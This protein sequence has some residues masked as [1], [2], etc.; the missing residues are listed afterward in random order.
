MTPFDSLLACAPA[1]QFR[2]ATSS[3][4]PAV[5]SRERFVAQIPRGPSADSGHLGS[6]LLSRTWQTRWIL[7]ADAIGLALVLIISFKWN[8]LAPELLLLAVLTL[9]IVVIV[10]FCMSATAAA[11]AAANPALP[12]SSTIQGPITVRLAPPR[13]ILIGNTDAGESNIIEHAV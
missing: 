5:A 3:G 10:H 9:L 12:V 1:E 2:P 8:I 4:N 6:G 7:A 13:S 11:A